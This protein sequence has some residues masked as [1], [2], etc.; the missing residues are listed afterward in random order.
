MGRNWRRGEVLLLGY[1]LYTFHHWPGRTSIES[2]KKIGTYLTIKESQVLTCSPSL[3]V[4]LVQVPAPE[5]R[6]G[7]SSPAK[8]VVPH[9]AC[10]PAPRDDVVRFHICCL[11]R[12]HQLI[13][14]LL[15]C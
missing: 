7:T 3:S 1:I 11:L 6:V 9:G 12:V 5:Q 10:V 8:L 15:H 14:L 2:A 4:E 13:T